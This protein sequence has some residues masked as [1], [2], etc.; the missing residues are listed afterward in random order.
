MP[1]SARDAGRV[2]HTLLHTYLKKILN[3]GWL[4]QMAFFSLPRGTF[5]IKRALLLIL[6]G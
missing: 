6:I 5:G 1:F 2:W 4:R 3:A